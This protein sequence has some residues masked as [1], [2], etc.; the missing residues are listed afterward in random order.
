VTVSSS[1]YSIVIT[2]ELGTAVVSVQGE[3]DVEGLTKLDVILA[4]VIDCQADRTVT[5][6][7]TAMSLADP[8]GAQVFR[9]ATDRAD[10][11]GATLRVEAPSPS[12]RRA[13]L[14]CGAARVID[15]TA[16]G[17]NRPDDHESESLPISG[18]RGAASHPSSLRRRGRSD[19]PWRRSGSP[20]SR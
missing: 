8:V 3:L 2:Q 9:R 17:K 11:R 5:V 18:P 14:M 20:S 15:V 19:H 6:D 12:L 13:L 7:A 10:E 4:D 1:G 16:G